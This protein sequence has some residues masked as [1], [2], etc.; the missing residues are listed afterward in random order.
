MVQR[1]NQAHDRSVPRRQ[2][3][4][5]LLLKMVALLVQIAGGIWTGSLA[6]LTDSVHLSADALGNVV[7]LF[8]MYHGERAVSSASQKRREA[9]GSLIIGVLVCLAATGIIWHAI[10]RLVSQAPDIL[11]GPMLLCA[12][13]GMLIN[14]INLYKLEPH[15]HIGLVHATAQHE[16]ADFL[17]SLAVVAGAAL[18]MV[19]GWNLADTILSFAIASYVFFNSGIGV[20]IRVIRQW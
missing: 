8:C 20:I 7:G 2:L 10:E 4:I 5:V 17:S 1:P 14:L 19:S 11:A 18:I 6:L 9:V 3:A 12:V 16:K 13:I 15:R